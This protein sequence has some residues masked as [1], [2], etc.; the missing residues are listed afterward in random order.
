MRED[1]SS[2]QRQ[3]WWGELGDE[4]CQ[5]MVD[6]LNRHRQAYFVS[7]DSGG[8]IIGC[9][10]AMADLLGLSPDEDRNESLWDKLTV[11]DAVRLNQRLKQPE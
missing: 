3:T 2:G 7:V 10:D 8:G 1:R 4:F 11:S 9:N 5:A 6:G